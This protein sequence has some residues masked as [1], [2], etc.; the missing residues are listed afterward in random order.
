MVTL[1]L[2]VLLCRKL[3]NLKSEYYSECLKLLAYICFCGLKIY[4]YSN[5][6]SLALSQLIS[7]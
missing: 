7:M 3:T 6:L 4:I 2:M 1:E 5:I